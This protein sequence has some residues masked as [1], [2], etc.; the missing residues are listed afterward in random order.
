MRCTIGQAESREIHKATKSVWAKK[1]QANMPPDKKLMN[2]TSLCVCMCPPRRS[3]LISRA[4]QE[5]E[6]ACALFK[7][8]A[9]KHSINTDQPNQTQTH[10]ADS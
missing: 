8:H 4:T 3:Q 6:G 10:K 2:I 7:Q 9:D 1:Y 5:G